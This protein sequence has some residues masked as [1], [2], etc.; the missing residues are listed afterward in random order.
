[1]KRAS[2]AA[3]D[4]RGVAE[5]SHQG[6]KR[7]IVRHWVGIAAALAD[8]KRE[9]LF[10]RAIIQNAAQSE[11]VSKQLAELAETLG[12]PTFGA[13]AAAGTQYDVTLEAELLEM[14]AYAAVVYLRN[15]QAEWRYGVAGS[16]AKRKLAVLIGNVDRGAVN[17]FGVEKRNADLANSLRGKADSVFDAAEER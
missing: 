4:A 12:R 13:P 9:I 7:T 11:R 15:L 14:I 10:A 17:F 5:K 1:M 3:D 8:G 2:I 6:T 16:C